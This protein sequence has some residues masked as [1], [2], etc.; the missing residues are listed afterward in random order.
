MKE[1]Y[2]KITLLSDTINIPVIDN[3]E[4]MVELSKTR[5]KVEYKKPDMILIVGKRIFVR[6]QV[7]EKLEIIQ[8]QLSEISNNFQ[9]FVCYGY[10]TPVVQETYFNDAMKRVKKQNK[11][12]SEEEH[13]ELAHSMC[14]HPK[15]AGHTVGGAVDLTIWDTKNEKEIDMGSQV[16]EFG[17]I[18]YTFYQHLTSAQ[19][20]N[21][22]LLKKLM[23]SQ[24]FAPFLG[25]WWHFS[26]GDKEWAFY[27]KQPNALYDVVKIESIAL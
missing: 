20:E 16:A 8:N 7:A 1:D 4:P 13:T 26:F 19:K 25:E 15:S 9:L 2:K 12:L 14:A 22:F 27:Y 17:D 3:S 5:F 21:R 6:K 10:R 24:G 18:A 23:T 11:H